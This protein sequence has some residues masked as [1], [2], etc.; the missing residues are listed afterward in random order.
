MPG[1]AAGTVK[2]CD[3]GWA[4]WWKPGCWHATLCGTPEFIPPELLEENPAY[5]PEFVDSWAVGVLTLEIVQKTTPF[6]PSLTVLRNIDNFMD[7]NEAIF[8]RIRKYS[9]DPVYESADPDL[10]DFVTRLMQVETSSRMTAEEALDHSF[11]R[12]A[13]PRRSVLTSIQSPSVAQRCQLF[14]KSCR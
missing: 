5:S 13:R 3:F 1:T 4:T 10:R 8:D 11:L 2:L 9:G 12:P 7:L 14:E 6:R